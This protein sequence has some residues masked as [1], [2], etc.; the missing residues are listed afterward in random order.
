MPLAV[1]SGKI[2]AELVLR[3][4]QGP[5]PRPTRAARATPV[6]PLGRDA[7]E[8]RRDLRIS[9]VLAL[10]FAVGFVGH[11][12]PAVRPF[13][14]AMTP[15]VLA[16]AGM[17][18]AAVALAD[19]GI[20]VALWAVG[21]YAVTFALEAAGVATGAIFGPYGYGA[22]LGP[23][24]LEVPVVIGFNWM[25]VVLGGVNLAGI[26]GIGRG[27]GG[28]TDGK[29]P[30]LVCVA[31][32]A[33]AACVI[34]DIRLEPVAER[35]DYCRFYT[36]SVPLQNYVA[37][38]LIAALSAFTFASRRCRVRSRLPAAYFLIQL[39]FFVGLALAG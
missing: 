12:I 19:G 38:F 33:G 37:W 3:H 2:A 18:V 39:A 29:G 5:A 8:R 34:L 20:P 26:I 4:E 23:K 17:V 10:F 1:L 30:C 6:A 32:A 35:L 21:T 15:A 27:V 28:R 13:M 36:T 25:L 22:T 24:V 11:L 14:L 16:V 7:V 9:L 31:V